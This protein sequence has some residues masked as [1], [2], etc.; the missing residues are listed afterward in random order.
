MG[1]GRTTPNSYKI[2]EVQPDWL[3]TRETMGTKKKVWYRQPEQQARD[4]LFKFPQENTGQHWAEKIAAEVAGF[5]R[6]RHARVELAVLG[7]IRGSATE[8]FTR[9]GRQLWHGN[10]VLAGTVRGYEPEKRFDQSNHTL[11]NVWQ[12]L[13][14]V[15]E[16]Q[17]AAR[18]AKHSLADYTVLDA[19]IGNTDRHH[20]NWGIL[21][22]RVGNRWRGAMAPS[23]D[24]ASSLGRELLNERRKSLLSENR[25]GHYAERGRGGIFWSDAESRAPSSLE[26]VRRAARTDPN[27]FRSALNR[28]QILD[29]CSVRSMVDSVPSDWMP[30]L[31]RQFAIEL[32][33]YNLNELRKLNGDC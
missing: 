15:F 30:P 14:R 18:R 13:D 2:Q 26:L 27:L 20:E 8:S 5:L 29:E 1:Y 16:D 23:F 7:D 28:L 9:G 11:A 22:K 31:A 4:W 25:V 3:L 17:D 10:Q 21:R 12:A 6:I 32:M 33:L 19:L 24:H